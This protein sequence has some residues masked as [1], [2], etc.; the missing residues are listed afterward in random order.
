MT[1]LV[2][3]NKAFSKLAPGVLQNLTEHPSLMKGMFLKHKSA[4]NRQN[5]VRL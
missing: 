3:D 1:L 5:Q 2:P 4:F